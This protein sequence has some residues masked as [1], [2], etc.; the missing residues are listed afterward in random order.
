MHHLDEM[1]LLVLGVSS[2]LLNSLIPKKFRR[3]RRRNQQM[4]VMLESVEDIGQIIITKCLPVQRNKLLSS[5]PDW[6]SVQQ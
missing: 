4:K 1:E 3:S 6:K 2:V 5:I